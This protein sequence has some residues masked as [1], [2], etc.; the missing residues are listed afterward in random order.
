MNIVNSTLVSSDSLN[1]EDIISRIKGIYNNCSPL[2]QKQLLKILEELSDKGYSETLEQ[3]YL[4]DFKEVPVSIER[5]L[6]DSE[7]LGGSNDNGNQIYPGWWEVYNSVFDSSRDIYE[8]CLSGATRI[9]KSSTAVSC[10]CYMTYLLMC[11]KNPQKYFGLKDVSR[12]TIAFANL[13]KDLAKGVAFREYNDTL[14]NSPWFNKHGTFTNSAKP[15]YIPEGDKIE[16]V[17][18]SDSA[19]VLGMQLWSCLIGDTKI[20]TDAGEHKISELDGQVVN[21][22]QYD[23]INNKFIYTSTQIKQTKL[24]TEL[25]TI[26]LENGVKITGTPE[27]R[28]MLSNGEYKMLQDLTVSDDILTVN[29]DESDILE[30]V[31]QVIG[32]DYK[33]HGEWRYLPDGTN[34]HAICSYG[35]LLIRLPYLDTLGRRVSGKICT[36]GELSGYYIGLHDFIH[37][38]MIRTFKPDEWDPE[39]DVNHKDGNKHNNH[40]DNLEMLTRS[41]NLNHYWR[42]DCFKEAREAS[43]AK[44]RPA[45]IQRALGNTYGKNR[46]HIYR[47]GEHRFCHVSELSNYLS[48]GWKLGTNIVTKGNAGLIWITDGI[49]NKQVTPVD[50]EECDKSIWHKGMTRPKNIK[51]WVHKD[52]KRMKILKEDVESYIA[53]GWALGSNTHNLGNTNNVA[54]TDG[55]HNKMIPKSE[56]PNISPP[57]RRGYTRKSRR[58]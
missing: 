57:W 56:L 40:I 1:Y 49:H 53:N 47:S 20:L 55:V 2:E 45:K 14:K 54:I 17:A 16:L 3:I 9:G 25:I 34:H 58:S 51:V 32:E 8:I 19:H 22:K 4:V 29:D 37:R 39:L 31:K 35:D 41:A 26:E 15:I 21:V 46:K 7:Y 52:D 23:Y 33:N 24:A 10:M 6:T 50:F 18:A 27:H 42:S 43:L 44:S 28:I 48:Q 12:A 5:F 13:T 11:Y 30:R 38:W 36:V